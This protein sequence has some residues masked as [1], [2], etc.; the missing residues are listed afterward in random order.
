MLGT[1]LL[2]ARCE[3]CHQELTGTMLEHV[4]G[5]CEQRAA[6]G[7]THGGDAK[8][9]KEHVNGRLLR[10]SVL[11]VKL[12]MSGGSRNEQL[13]TTCRWQLPRTEHR[14]C[15]S[16]M[17]LW[18]SLQREH[19]QRHAVHE[20]S[21]MGKDTRSQHWHHATAQSHTGCSRCK[22]TQWC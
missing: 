18:V 15:C 5:L 9:V 12:I 1:V 10:G 22:C 2:L 13:H 4:G 6:Q 8:H 16:R 3:R 21:I 7:F 11:E 14:Q 20:T 17:R 19:L